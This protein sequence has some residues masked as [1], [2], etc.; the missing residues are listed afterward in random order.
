M[1]H[2]IKHIVIENKF[3]D[4]GV[5]IITTYNQ[6]NAFRIYESIKIDEDDATIYPNRGK[7]G[8]EVSI[9]IKND[10]YQY[11]VFFLEDETR[12]FMYENMGVDPQYIRSADRDGIIRIRV[13]ESLQT[14]KTYKVIITN[15]LENKKGA[16]KDLT[17]D[18]TKQ[19]TIG[20]FYVV[21]A[22]V[23]PTITKV[24]P[25]EGTSAG[26][27]V[28]IYGHRFEELKIGGYRG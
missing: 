27:Y 1:D 14:G 21:D 15:N 22:D 17:D 13:P 18:V 24:V 11:S 16:G 19:A 12:P 28:T 2:G 26:S 25:N 9:T 10:Q 3:D 5:D 20:E 7:K 23:G 4:N 6:R 8:T